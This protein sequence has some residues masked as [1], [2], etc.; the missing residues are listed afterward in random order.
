MGTIQFFNIA[1]YANKGYQTFV[2]S[3]TGKGLGVAHVREYFE[4]VVSVEYMES[5]H[6]EAF[7]KFRNFLRVFIFL[8]V[9]WEIFETILPY[10]S[11]KCVFWLDAHLPGVDYQLAEDDEANPNI[12]MPL[13]K[14]LETIKRLRSGQDVILI[15]DLRFYIKDDFENGNLPD[16]FI[17]NGYNHILSMFKETHQ[18]KKHLNDDGYLEMIPLDFNQTR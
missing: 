7:F 8:G 2:E 14:E 12:R 18:I 9:S 3:G 10:I 4:T 1:E 15:D 5:L 11:G 13:V 6:K 17:T 16:R